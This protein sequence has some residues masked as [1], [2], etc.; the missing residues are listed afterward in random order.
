MPRFFVDNTQI[1]TE[2]IRIIGGDAR[3]IEVLRM[4]PSDE[5]AVVDGLY[6]YTCR[7]ASICKNEVLVNIIDKTQVSTEPDV[8]VT[9]FIPS[10][11]SSAPDV[12]IS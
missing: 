8:K 10:M 6:V 1:S 2:F 12:F 7:I 5:I 9:L 11:V 3:H 4:S